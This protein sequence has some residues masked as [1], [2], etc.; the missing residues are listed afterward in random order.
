[1]SVIKIAI[2]SDLHC[3]YGGDANSKPSTYLL[4]DLL[5]NPINKHPVESIKHIIRKSNITADLI[6]CPGDIT[7]RVNKQGLVSGWQFLKEIKEALGAKE[8]IVTIGN[9]DVDSKNEHK[10]GAFELI[11]NIDDSI[12]TSNQSS[13]DSYWRY[14]YCI[15]E[16][17]N[18]LL[19]NIN[20]CF[21]HTSPDLAKTTQI[22]EQ[23]LKQ[24]EEGLSAIK[25]DKVRIALC[26]HHPLHHSNSSIAFK[27]SDFIDQSDKLLMLLEKQ[28]FNLVIHGH[29]HDPRLVYFNSGLPVLASGSFS[30]TSNLLDLGAQNTFH[31]I[32]IDSVSKKGKIISWIYLPHSGWTQRL[33]SY[34]PCY[35]GFGC[36]I[37]L[38]DLAMKCKE[39]FDKQGKDFQLYHDASLN[40]PDIDHLI[41][42][43]Q[44]KFNELMKNT[45]GLT[46]EP[47][48][49]NKPERIYKL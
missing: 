24:I 32:E 31:L 33:D 45:H 36:K 12:P 39:W 21:N 27:D 4:S 40:F 49:P 37:P 9:H 29:K 41:P 20:S 28:D 22:Q 19:L 7:D 35:T 10:M 43:Q 23:T 16:V 11:K 14:G 17:G 18:V 48:L 30:A 34:F 15:H 47:H 5:K 2:A 44:E 42:S 38:D 1:M 13:N 26:H 8:L 25:S 46:F 6:L 3:A